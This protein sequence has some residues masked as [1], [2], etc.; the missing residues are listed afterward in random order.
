MHGEFDFEF[1]WGPSMKL[2]HES[3]EL[4]EP[5]ELP[6]VR[7]FYEHVGYGGGVQATD[8][9]LVIRVGQ[10]IVAAVRLCEEHGTLVLRGMYVDAE[11][12][13]Q[14]YGVQLLE[15]AGNLIGAA[16]CWCV[17][18]AHLVQFYS[19]AGFREKET[20]SI[21]GFLVE[22]Q[23]QYERRGHAVSVMQR[24]AR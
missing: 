5:E 6:S 17:P 8:Q 11:Y 18:H 14:G 4:V 15:S 21:P 2:S 10:K 20:D 12:R 23:A 3:V 19:R 13:S 9:V 24:A 22:R 16:E 1:V 7:V